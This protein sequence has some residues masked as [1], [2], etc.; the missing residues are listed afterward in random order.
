[1]ISL[2]RNVRMFLARRAY[3][4]R[5][6]PFTLKSGK[7][8]Q[9][10]VDCRPLLLEPAY[11]RDICALLHAVAVAG[12]AE[13]AAT[14]GVA[15]GGIPLAEG[16]AACFSP[17]MPLVYVRAEPKG[18]GTRKLVELPLNPLRSALLVEDVATTGES[19]ARAVEALRE[20][21]I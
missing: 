3:Q 14:A 10:Y 19:A 21:R 9:H 2:R 7:Q 5:N 18:H 6:E 16:V 13:V 12:G 17:R 15:L 20:E 11:R 8:S 1:M 4:F